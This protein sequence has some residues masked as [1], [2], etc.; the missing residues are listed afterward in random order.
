VTVTVGD[1]S[2]D[3]GFIPVNDV[4]GVFASI[5][6]TSVG[7][8]GVFDAPSGMFHGAVKSVDIRSGNH[9]IEKW[10]F[11]GHGSTTT[12]NNGSVLQLGTASWIQG[13]H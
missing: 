9:W 10:R 4:N 12:G 3:L 5:E 2:Y 8:D 6:R 13:N 7:G 11:A 1:Q